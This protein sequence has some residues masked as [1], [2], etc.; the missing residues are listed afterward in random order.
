MA[1]KK[2]LL[3]ESNPMFLYTLNDIDH[4]EN[5]VIYHKKCISKNRLLNLIFNIHNSGKIHKYFNLPY[6]SIWDKILFNKLLKSFTPDYIIFTTSWYSDHLI[7]YFRKRCQNSKLIFRF[8]DMVSNGLGE[9]YKLKITK[10]RGQFNGVLVYSQED[11]E[12][13]GFVYHSVGYSAI[14]RVL[15]KPCKKYDVVFIGAEK[16]R[17]EKI[18]QAYNIF[19]SAGLSCFFYVTLVRKEDRKEDGIIY[20]DKGMSYFDYLSY[21]ISAKCLFEIVQDGSS[22]RTFRMM[23]SIMYN[24]LLITNCTEIK[25]T[26]YYFPNYVQLYSMVS[27]IEPSFIINNSCVIDYHYKGDFSPKRVLEFVERNW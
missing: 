13:Y 19:M 3:L 15:L 24:K 18:R 8:T 5:L 9:K 10:I 27:E 23:E 21:E 2:F 4:M 22:G 1:K 16:G 6:K 20:A 26:D 12:E 11:A 14:N 7:N 17:I 25:K